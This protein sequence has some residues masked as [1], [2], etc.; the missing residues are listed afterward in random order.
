M[1]TNL[2]QTSSAEL[3]FIKTSPKHFFLSS[4]GGQYTDHKILYTVLSMY[5][6]QLE[7]I[8]PTGKK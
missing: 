5:V 2:I 8:S 4:G 3:D 7:Y 6:I 1:N